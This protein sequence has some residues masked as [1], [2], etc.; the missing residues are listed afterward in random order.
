MSETDRVEGDEVILHIRRYGSR[1]GSW[2]GVIVGILFIVG[3]VMAYYWYLTEVPNE[4]CCGILITVV[5]IVI[6]YVIVVEIDNRRA[7]TV[8]VCTDMISCM[9][10]KGKGPIITWGP[11]VHVDVKRDDR[12]TDPEFGPLAEAEVIL[13]PFR[14]YQQNL[15]CT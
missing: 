11:D 4:F 5:L 9:D 7:L 3:L 6:V 8:D 14:L 12:Y 13:P 1:G 10:K 15:H 2:T